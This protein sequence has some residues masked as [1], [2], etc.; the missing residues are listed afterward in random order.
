MYAQ[1]IF[2]G[3]FWWW[4]VACY[5][6]VFFPLLASPV[7]VWGIRY[8]RGWNTSRRIGLTRLRS[9]YHRLPDVSRCT[10]GREG[11]ACSFPLYPPSFFYYYFFFF[12]SALLVVGYIGR[13]GMIF[14]WMTNILQGCHWLL[15]DLRIGMPVETFLFDWLVDGFS[16][17][18]TAPL[19]PVSSDWWDWIWI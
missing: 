12:I 10:R 7:W 1:R 13:S 17:H 18:S 11:G 16:V 2:R 6:S 14:Y 8:G 9:C 3:G 5:V 4:D 15:L 19:S